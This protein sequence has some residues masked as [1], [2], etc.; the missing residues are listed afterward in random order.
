MEIQDF[1]GKP[2]L[3]TGDEGFE[4]SGHLASRE[5]LRLGLY[6]EILTYTFAG[7]QWSAWVC[8]T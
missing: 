4:S 5:N 7:I 2:V 6:Q 8:M 1:N 3:Q